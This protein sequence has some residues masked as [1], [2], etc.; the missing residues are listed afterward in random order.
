[1]KNVPRHSIPF[2]HILN[3]VF[4]RTYTLLKDQVCIKEKT[5]IHVYDMSQTLHD[6]WAKHSSQSPCRLP[7][8]IWAF[9]V[10]D[11]RQ[12][13]QTETVILRPRM[14]FSRN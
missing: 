11:L 3:I 8:R 9:P 2:D 12:E 1:M 4:K 13:G 7:E 6:R 10:E 5:I 14:A